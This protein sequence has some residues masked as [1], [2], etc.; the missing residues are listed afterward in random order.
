MPVPSQ[1]SQWL[2]PISALQATPTLATSK[3]TLEKELYDRSRGVEFLFRLG[4]S[5]GL[6]VR[7][8]DFI[9]GCSLSSVSGSHLDPPLPCLLLPLG[10][11]GF[12]CGTRWRTT[13][14]KLILLLLLFNCRFTEPLLTRSRFLRSVP[15]FTSGCCRVLHIPSDKNRR[16]WT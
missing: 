6:F 15:V 16:V 4:S 9:I 12:I 3:W 11:I 7:R 5:L 8:S 10:F 14:D 1:P 13:T 2:F